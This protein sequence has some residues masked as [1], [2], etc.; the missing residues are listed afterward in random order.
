M[1]VD[2][3]DTEAAKLSW[4]GKLMLARVGTKKRRQT[5]TSNRLAFALQQSPRQA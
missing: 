1:G 2:G 5:T 4:R 3:W